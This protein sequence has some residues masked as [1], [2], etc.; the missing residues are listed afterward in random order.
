MGAAWYQVLA[1]V[2][3]WPQ[4]GVGGL[5]PTP[6][7]ERAASATMLEGKARAPYVITGA[8]SEG[9]SS[10]RAMAHLRRPL[11]RAA[12]TKSRDVR[13]S[14]WART[15]FEMPDQPMPPRTRA[16]RT[17]RGKVSG[18][19]ARSAR[20]MTMSGRATLMSVTRLRS[21]S[22]RRLP[23][24][25]VRPMTRPRVICRKVATRATPSETRAP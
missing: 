19:I 8:A 3:I 21:W 24:A 4:D 5:M 20:A 16:I 17:G 11:S 15:I 1:S 6:R 9:S 12:A 25:A 18:T 23:S 10:R 7:K 2:S 22:T 14:A 13:A